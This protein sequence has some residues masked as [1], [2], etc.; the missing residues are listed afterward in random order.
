MARAMWLSVLMALAWVSCAG[1]AAPLVHTLDRS[2]L[3]ALLTERGQQ[4]LREQNGGVIAARRG[5]PELW[6]ALA[7]CAPSGACGFLRMRGAWPVGSRQAALKAAEEY[8]SSVPLAFLSIEN[9]EGQN[10]VLAGRDVWIRPGRSRAN[11]LVELALAERLLADVTTALLNA[12]PG[13]AEYW[14]RALAQR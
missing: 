6:L 7:D 14:E 4:V 1:A 13:L 2:G 10:V 11:L 3:E 9:R 5:G 12:D 8:D